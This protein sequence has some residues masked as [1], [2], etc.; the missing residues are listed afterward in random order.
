MSLSFMCALFPEGGVVPLKKGS[1]QRGKNQKTTKDENLWPAKQWRHHYYGAKIT[2]LGPAG[3]QKNEHYRVQHL[4]LDP[5]LRCNDMGAGDFLQPIAGITE[6]EG[7][8]LNIFF[9]TVSIPCVYVGGEGLSCLMYV[10][11]GR[12]LL[13]RVI[14]TYSNNHY[15]CYALALL[16]IA[17][18]VIT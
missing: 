4:K 5:C 14:R 2:L 13:T 3:G 7:F 8:G 18:L 11:L 12:S 1:I 10:M 9:R 17:R 6:R 15:Y 16:S